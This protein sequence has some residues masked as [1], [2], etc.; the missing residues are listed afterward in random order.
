MD[1]RK[2]E[3][4]SQLIASI[5]ANQTLDPA[6]TLSSL[7]QLQSEAVAQAIGRVWSSLTSERRELFSQWLP[8]PKS[9]RSARRLALLAAA[10]L[11]VDGLTA[12]RWLSRLI[13][14]SAKGKISRELGQTIAG[15]FFG[16]KPLRFT[17]LGDEGGRPEELLRLMRALLEVAID[18]HFTIERMARYRLVEDLLAII[19][20]R[21]LGGNDQC[22]PILARIEIEFK[23]WPQALLDQLAES[24][25]RRNLDGD[26]LLEFGHPLPKSKTVPVAQGEIASVE[27]L[28]K[29]S[30]AQFKSS[31]DKTRIKSALEQR[32]TSLSSEIDT[33][34]AL[35]TFVSEAE[36]SQEEL[37]R[38]LQ[39]SEARESSLQIRLKQVSD[40][41]E[42]TLAKLSV[43]RVQIEELE[44]ANKLTKESME[45]ERQR[46]TQQITA[47]AS[48]R[49]EEFKNNLTLVLSRLILDL[50]ARD[51]PLR[52]DV[53]QIVFL[54]FHQFLDVLD[55]QGIKI[56]KLKGAV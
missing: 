41:L 31:V 47:N 35:T 16:S 19:S 18:D 27:T 11:E 1:A 9:E 28:P 30:E 25:K 33:L 7:E 42:D 55:G 24:V 56:R 10:V 48:G 5:W 20:Q 29:R 8:E 3:Q 52:P 49:V 22:K 21:K 23:R 44:R 34:K 17:R 43:A 6:E 50:P 54:Q 14:E 46:L 51:A 2:R 12:L 38:K 4:A 39:E 45:A 15:V 37:E 40:E 13:S 53:G 26:L 32:I 36:H